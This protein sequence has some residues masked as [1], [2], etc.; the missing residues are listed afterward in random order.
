M[1][2]KQIPFSLGII[3]SAVLPVMSF[4]S[5]V[6]AFQWQHLLNGI[7]SQGKAF[8]PLHASLP[9]MKGV[10]LQA[11]STYVFAAVD[12]RQAVF[13]ESDCDLLHAS[14][15]ERARSTIYF[16]T[17]A[18]ELDAAFMLLEGRPEPIHASMAEIFQ[19]YLKRRSFW[20]EYAKGFPMGLGRRAA[21]NAPLSELKKSA[22]VQTLPV[23]IP[24]LFIGDKTSKT[25]ISGIAPKNERRSKISARIQKTVKS[26]VPALAAAKTAQDFGQIIVGG[27]AT[28]MQFVSPEIS[29]SIGPSGEILTWALV[30]AVFGYT[31]YH[32]W[33]SDTGLVQWVKKAVTRYL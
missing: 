19:E 24:A 21:P 31:F 15:C 17:G 30:A 6:S 29:A 2:Q 3:L 10:G 4:A 7:R 12:D 8:A 20:L 23:E 18:G 13:I 25:P 16:A 11:G 28:A 27:L 14:T 26:L 32:S 33:K 22:V 1:K 9:R 5:G